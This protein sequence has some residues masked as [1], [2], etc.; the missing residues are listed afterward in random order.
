GQAAEGVIWDLPAEKLPEQ[1]AKTNQSETP[2]D[3]FRTQH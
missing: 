1:P 3:R 2:M